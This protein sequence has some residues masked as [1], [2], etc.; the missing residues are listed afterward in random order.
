M[1]SDKLFQTAHVSFSNGKQNYL[2]A[3][4]H[5]TLWAWTPMDMIKWYSI[6]LSVNGLEMLFLSQR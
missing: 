6:V 4:A 3:H 5:G 1:Y 2:T